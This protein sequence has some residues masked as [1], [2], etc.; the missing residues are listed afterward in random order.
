M[1]RIITLFV[2]IF[3]GGGWLDG[4]KAKSCFL[5]LCEDVSCKGKSLYTKT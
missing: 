5:S 1:V 4:C 2:I 3:V